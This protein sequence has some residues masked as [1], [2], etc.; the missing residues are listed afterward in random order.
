MC[1]MAYAAM[2]KFPNCCGNWPR[3]LACAMRAFC[4]IATPNLTRWNMTK[5]IPNERR[6]KKSLKNQRPN[7][8]NNNDQ[9]THGARKHAWR[10]QAVWANLMINLISFIKLISLVILI[11]LIEFCDH[12]A[13]VPRQ[14]KLSVMFPPAMV[15]CRSPGTI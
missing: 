11:S 5:K 2:L 7:D 4:T 6:K 3:Q 12:A 9:A 8:G 13:S 14:D 10:T 15:R 1:H